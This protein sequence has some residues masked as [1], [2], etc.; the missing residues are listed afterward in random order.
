[1]IFDFE[2]LDRVGECWLWTGPLKGKYGGARL[3][4][5][6]VYAHRL[7]YELAIGPIPDGLT[8]DHLCE[9]KLCCRPEHLEA[10]TQQENNQRGWNNRITENYL[11]G[12]SRNADNT[13]VISRGK[14]RICRQCALTDS[15]NRYAAKKEGGAAC[16]F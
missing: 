11:C 4:G 6:S 1:M 12:H 10:V 7:A 15:R 9:T 8:I 16:G 13:Y 5:K 3:D 14:G 2:S